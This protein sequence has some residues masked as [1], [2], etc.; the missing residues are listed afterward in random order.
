MTTPMI[1]SATAISFDGTPHT[2]DVIYFAW[3]KVEA[4]LE[5]QPTTSIFPGGPATL[6]WTTKY[7]KDAMSLPLN[8]TLSQP[9]GQMDVTPFATTTYTIIATNPFSPLAS[10]TAT[11][12]V[13]GTGTLL[14][15]YLGAALAQGTPGRDHQVNFEISGHFTGAGSG[16]GNTT[17]PANTT[18]N[19]VDIVTRTFSPTAP[20]EFSKSYSNLRPGPWLIKVRAPNQAE[21]T[22]GTTVVA[23]GS[24]TLSS[25]PNLPSCQ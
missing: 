16:L 25:R 6:K 10:A 1:V 15:K 13:S 18:A 2:I 24:V 23:Q 8:V 17:I 5:A 12:M 19:P 7:A 14:V 9:N 20:W 3:G 21:V 4:T 11:V 22:C